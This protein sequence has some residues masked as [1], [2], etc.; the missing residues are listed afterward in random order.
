MKL[1]RFII[2]SANKIMK[3]ETLVWQ[4]ITL[5]LGL[6]FIFIIKTYLINKIINEAM[7]NDTETMSKRASCFALTEEKNLIDDYCKEI[8]TSLY[9]QK[10]FDDIKK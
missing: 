1:A 7:N 4:I 3:K 9:T 5:I 8:D 10:F 6:F 2:G